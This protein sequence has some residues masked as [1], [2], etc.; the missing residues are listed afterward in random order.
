MAFA[1]KA[2]D[3]YK[4]LFILRWVELVQNTGARKRERGQ[5]GGTRVFFPSFPPAAQKRGGDSELKETE[6][7]EDYKI[8]F[9]YD[10]KRFSEGGKG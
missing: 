10:L 7:K 2:P 6:K 9:A 3:F 5:S 1:G 8:F 4:R